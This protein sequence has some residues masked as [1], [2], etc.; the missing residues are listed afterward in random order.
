MLAA[1]CRFIRDNMRTKSL[2]FFAVIA[3]V[4]SIS[5][6]SGTAAAQGKVKRDNFTPAEVDIVRDAQDLDVR[7]AVFVIAIDR[8][9]AVLAGSTVDPAKPAKPPKGWPEWGDMPTGTPAQLYYDIQHILDEGIN[10]IDDAASR[11]PENLTMMRGVR[12]LGEA[13]VRIMPKL[14]EFEAKSADEKEKVSL[15]AA[16]E[17][18][19]SVI[20][21]MK[22]IPADLEQKIKEMEKKEKKE[23]KK[24]RDN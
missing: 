3:F 22:K 2:L 13:C 11:E 4:F 9:L 18:A 12:V 7:M 24:D 16:I 20:D 23:R 21:A 14:R 15:G 19:Q 10:N 5:G 6:F 17:H 1:S 8:R